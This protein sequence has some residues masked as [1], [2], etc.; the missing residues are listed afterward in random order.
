MDIEKDKLTLQLAARI[1][2]EEEWAQIVT[3]AS[4]RDVVLLFPNVKV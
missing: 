1:Q 3:R 2:T 4:P